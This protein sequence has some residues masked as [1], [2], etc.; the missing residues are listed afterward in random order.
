[1]CDPNS[2]LTNPFSAARLRPGTI[3]FI[4]EHGV[5]LGQ[6]VDALEANRWRGEIIGQHGTGKSTLLTALVPAIAARGRV[7][8]V[9]TL[10]SG[11][12]RLPEG[13]LAALRVTAGLGV[14]VIDGFE[15]L[16]LLN[17]WRLRRCCR[18]QGTGLLV[19]MHRTAG[20]PRIYQTKIDVPRAWMVVQRFQ[21]GFAPLVKLSDLVERL[22]Q[23]QLNLR[24]ALF[25][26]Y[27][28]YESR[29]LAG[30]A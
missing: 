20:M 12:R 24:E 3:S 25:D 5:N 7:V 10:A 26:L 16:G 28:V 13:Y 9:A 2:S 4:F 27:D 11:Q 18:S 8:K 21:E 23:R 30:S 29:R 1:M 22:A 19:A 17:R 15:Q 6:L 14:A